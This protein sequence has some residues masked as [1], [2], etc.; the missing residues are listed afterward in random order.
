[1]RARDEDDA[2]AIAR[3]AVRRVGLAGVSERIASQLTTK[4]LRL[5]ELA[6]AVAGKPEI[7]LLDETLAGLG[8]EEGKE[9]VKVIRNLAATGLTIVI[10]EHTMQAMVQLVDRFIVLDHGELLAEGLPGE[11]TKDPRVIE[12]YLGS[13]WAAN[14]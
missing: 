11:I 13:K 2:E 7:L 8:A 1:M 14:A 5:M 10:I 9:V 6:R 3:E 4:E 12:A